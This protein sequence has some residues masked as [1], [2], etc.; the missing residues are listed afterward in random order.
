MTSKKAL[1]EALVSVRF[2]KNLAIDVND[3]EYY[4]GYKAVEDK[5]KEAMALME[6]YN[7]I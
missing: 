2:D 7:L 3:K 5:L 4:E 6:K 1:E